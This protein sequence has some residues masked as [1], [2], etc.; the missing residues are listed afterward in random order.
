MRYGRMCLRS[1]FA[2]ALLPTWQCARRPAWSPINETESAGV[3]G[4]EISPNVHR[5]TVGQGAFVGVYAPNVY[6]VIGNSGA[7]FIDTAYGSDEEVKAHLELWGAQGSPRVDAIIL[8]HR[9][10]DHIGGADR[11][12]VATRGPVHS[13]AV[14][15]RPIEESLNEVQVGA[16]VAD[17]E[18][19]DLG[20]ATLEFI[21]TPGHTM[22]SLCVYHREEGILF[23]GDT[24]LGSGTT[25]IP[26]G[27]GDMAAY[28][29]SLRKLLAYDA[30][31]ICPGHGP[32]IDHPEAKINGLIKHRLDRE[33]QILNLLKEGHRTVDDL[34]KTIYPELDGRLHDTARNQ[35]RSHLTKLES[36]GKAEQVEGG[37]APV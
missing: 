27:Q 30:R 13:T 17:G 16:V 3:V 20:G 11:L 37:Y 2:G 15:K 32:V 29:E 25:V 34:L 36:E 9:H 28:I 4:V 1:W 23:T 22:G 33:D 14:E 7:A 10:T 26:P 19:L 5:V 8:T 12:N 18:T 35:I 24:I 31:K 21:H 6:L